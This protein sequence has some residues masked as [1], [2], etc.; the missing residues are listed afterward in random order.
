MTTNS[1]RLDELLVKLD[2]MSQIKP[3]QRPIFK[4]KNVSIRNY[5]SVITPI[6]RSISG[7]SRNDIIDGFEDTYN[8]IIRL[9]KDY[10]D[11]L[12]QYNPLIEQCDISTASIIITAISNI[13]N[14][15]IL[16][17]ETDEMGINALLVTYNNDSEFIAKMKN[18][19]SKFMDVYRKNTI[20]IDRISRKYN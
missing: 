18:I 7:E 2:I 8:D 4:N 5:Y 10:T 12:V 9:V 19:K 13:N 17:Y 15:I 20:E 3:L 1:Q 14:K 6:I 16:L 11:M